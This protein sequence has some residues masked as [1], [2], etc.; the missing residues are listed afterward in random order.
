MIEHFNRLFPA[1]Y[2]PLFTALYAGFMSFIALCGM[3]VV[4]P[5]STWAWLVVLLFAGVGMVLQFATKRVLI[6]R[7][8]DSMMYALAAGASALLTWSLLVLAW[9]QGS[10]VLAAATITAMLIG[11]GAVTVVRDR[12]NPKRVRLPCAAIGKMDQ[13]TG[14]ITDPR[15]IDRTPVAAQQGNAATKAVLSLAPLI[16]GLSM[17][18]VRGLPD[19]AAILLLLFPGTLFAVMMTWFVAKSMSFLIGTLR[20]ERDHGKRIY[21][22]R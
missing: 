14:L 3:V 1:A 17:M 21:V 22:K 15:Y 5:A 8:Y 16:A 20:W 12:R 10:A 13:N 2:S 11:F 4:S 7:L 18:L 6:I 9:G 19:D